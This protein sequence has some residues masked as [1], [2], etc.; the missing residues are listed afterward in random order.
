MVA[1]LF[2]ISFLST[3]NMRFV[4]NIF[5]AKI[6]QNSH[7]GTLSI[8][9]DLQNGQTANSGP[10]LGLDPLFTI[11]CRNIQCTFSCQL[12]FSA[13]IYSLVSCRYTNTLLLSYNRTGRSGISILLDATLSIFLHMTNIKA[14]KCDGIFFF[15]QYPGKKQ[16]YSL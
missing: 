5:C 16:N 11:Y 6:P 15:H 2:H 8:A 10:N 9:S 14:R 1:I 13:D 4:L 12:F 3:Y 7:C